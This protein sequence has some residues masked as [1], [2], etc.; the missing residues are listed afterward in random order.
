MKQIQSSVSLANVKG[1]LIAV[2]KNNID[3]EIVL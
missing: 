3:N 2:L 1:I